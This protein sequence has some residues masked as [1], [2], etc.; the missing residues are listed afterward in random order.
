M[1]QELY[2]RESYL[3]LF[4]DNAKDS[5]TVF[6]KNNKI[7]E[8]NPAFEELYGWKREEV[9]GQ[10]VT[11]ISPQY[12]LD[13]ARRQEVLNGASYHF[14]ETTDRKK[15]VLILMLKSLFLLY[16]IT[17]RSLLL[18]LSLV[19]MSALKKRQKLYYYNQK[20]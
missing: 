2:S 13:E 19:E 11:I 18:S 20:S 1:R 6:D 14:L 16:M 3:Q 17:T 12:Q 7:I 8:V 15:M 4:F 10:S 9:I 5:I